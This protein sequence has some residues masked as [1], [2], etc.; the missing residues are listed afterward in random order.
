MSTAQP[1]RPKMIWLPMAGSL[2]GLL[3]FVALS[4]ALT[5]YKPAPEREVSEPEAVKKVEDNA[6]D[7]TPGEKSEPSDR[8][9]E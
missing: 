3:L 2:L 9:P 8:E 7:E 6:A 1:N 5:R 4:F